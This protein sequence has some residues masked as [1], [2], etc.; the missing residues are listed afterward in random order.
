MTGIVS[1]GA[2]I[3]IYRL[4]REEIARAWSRG[5]GGGERSVANFDEDSATM[6][7]EAI[8]DCLGDIDR[9]TVDGLYFASTTPPYKEKQTASLVAQACDLRR[10][11]F[12]ADFSDSVRSGTMALRAALDAVKSG[13]AS[14][15]M[16]A[17]ADCRL[18][19]PQSGFEQDYGDG[20][21]AL[22]IGDENVICEIEDVYTHTDDIMDTWRTKND[23]FV[24]SWEDRFVLTEGYARNIEEAVKGLMSKCGLQPSDIT[25]LVLYAPD[26]RRSLDMSKALGFDPKTQVQDPMFKALG[27]TGAA[28]AI[29]MLAAALEEAKQ[30]D[31]ILLANYGD[32]ADAYLLKVT[33]EITKLP[34][35]RGMKAHLASKLDLANYEKYVRFRKVMGLESQA[36][37]GANAF[38]PV[39]WREREQLTSLHGSRCKACGRTFHPM[40]RV[41][42]Y[43]GAKD[44]FEG[45]RL[46][47][48]KG[49][50]YTYC[51]DNLALSGD[52]P[53]V[54]GKVHIEDEKGPI[55]IY[56]QM[57]D[58][59]QDKV[60]P[61]VPVEMTFRKMHDAGNMHTYYWKCRLPREA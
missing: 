8:I 45:V 17:A 51:I 22:L 47:D 40:Q 37:E 32:G 1:Y 11:I 19:Q 57:T 25:K 13:S 20:S 18:G 26:A 50:L 30:G 31:R 48:R 28:F 52:P 21:A 60:Q 53:T 42:I 56:C 49:T 41:C 36:R 61:D 6:A 38:P 34:K 7:V 12:A 24:R 10:K 58:R 3:P 55:G 54:V 59:D 14:K 29:M 9:E 39:A 23:T 27:N 46:S 4:K 2:Y 35:C 16:V 43:C 5:S 15:V 44:Q 33:D